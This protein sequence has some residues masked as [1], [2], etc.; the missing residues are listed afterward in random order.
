MSVADFYKA[1]MQSL[2]TLGIDIRIWT[3]PVEIPDPIPF[4]KDERTRPR[5]RAGERILASARSIGPV[6]KN[7]AAAS[8]ASAARFISSGAASIWR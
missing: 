4:E 6:F 7:F 8:S 1:V 2:H 3:M 5:R